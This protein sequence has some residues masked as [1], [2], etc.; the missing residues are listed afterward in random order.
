MSPERTLGPIAT[1]LDQP[2]TTGCGLC[3]LTGYGERTSSGGRTYLRLRLEDAH[4][5]AT[6]FVWP[7][8]RAGITLGATPVPV[9]VA[10]TLE[11]FQ[12]HAQLRAH[13]LAMADPDALESA[14]ALLPFARCPAAARAALERVG[15]L[16]AALPAPLSGFLRRVL[17][18][19]ALGLPLLR[20]RASVAHHHAYPG[21][22]LVHSTELLDVATTLAQRTL[23]P[24]PG[25]LRSR[26]SAICC[27]TWASCVASVKPTGPTS[28]CWSATS[29]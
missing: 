5:H 11:A 26:N 9:R 6:G 13:S 19:P 25:R 29:C 7:E 23:P 1:W 20:C 27:T 28:A 18:D 17:L 22:L 3:L 21:G 10:G 2:G 12:G 8:A 16:E 24:I 15:Q 14:T 4:G